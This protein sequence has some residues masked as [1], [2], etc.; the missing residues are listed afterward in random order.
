VAPQSVFYS[1]STVWRCS[2]Y[3]TVILLCG[4]A[5]FF[6]VYDDVALQSN[7]LLCDVDLQSVFYFYGV[8]LQSFLVYDDVALQSVFTSTACNLFLLSY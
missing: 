2:L 5:F 6:L 7:F 1:T 8:A 4:A 3:F